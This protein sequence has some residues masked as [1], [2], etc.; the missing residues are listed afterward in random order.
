MDGVCLLSHGVWHILCDVMEGAL[1]LHD[2][3]EMPRGE[4]K[5]I[6]QGWAEQPEKGT[7]PIG[8]VAVAAPSDPSGWLKL[9]R[10]IFTL[11]QFSGCREAPGEPGEGLSQEGFSPLPWPL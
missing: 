1:G 9:T 5:G 6:V 8:P 3:G 4:R 2:R 10:V 7:L 11:C